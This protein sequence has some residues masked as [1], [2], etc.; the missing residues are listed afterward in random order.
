MGIR[1]KMVK[2][3]ANP[4]M[5]YMDQAKFDLEEIVDHVDLATTLAMLAGICYD[6]GIHLIENW[7]DRGAAKEWEKMGDKL[8]K[9]SNVSNV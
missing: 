8:M 3:R 5:N 7:N 4:G 6:K 9:L 1:E 2:A